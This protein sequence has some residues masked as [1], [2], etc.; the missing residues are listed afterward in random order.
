MYEGLPNA[1]LTLM[2]SDG[3]LIY[4]ER[5]Q[6]GYHTSNW[7]IGDPAENRRIADDY[8]QKLGVTKAQEE[9]MLGGSM[10]GWD[11]SAADPKRYENLP[12]Q[13]IN[14]GYAIIRRVTLGGIEIVLGES[15]SESG[16]YVTWRRTP[17]HEH[18]GRPEYYWGHYF[19]NKSRA[20][21]DFDSR[22]EE[23]RLQSKKYKEESTAS[24]KRNV[25]ER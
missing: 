24:K 12:A 3:R 4:I 5:G 17:A 19:N 18:H 9:A 1:C 6:S 21:A 22:V 13:A 16:N 10:F 8:N 23:E 2:P 20:M 11:T 14:A 25:P 7:D 15:T